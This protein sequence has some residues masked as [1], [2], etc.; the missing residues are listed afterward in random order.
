[1]GSPLSRRDIMINI[2]LQTGDSPK[3]CDFQRGYF[4]SK[5]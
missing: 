1:L 2:G 3:T 5:N 4:M